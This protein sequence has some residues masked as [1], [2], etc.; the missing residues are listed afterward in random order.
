MCV[1]GSSSGGNCIY[2]ASDATAILIDAGLSARDTL[3]RL[4]QIGVAAAGLAAICLTHEH[5]DHT[6]GL[7][8]LHRRTGAQLFANSGTIEALA[9]R[10]GPGALP[11]NVFTTGSA[12]RIG[13]LELEPFSVPHDAYD[14]VGFVVA[15][16]GARVGIVTDMG[17]ATGLIRERLR[18]CHAIV[19]E[20]NHDAELLHDAERPW[21]LKQR[22]QGRQGHLSNADAAALITE[23]AGP[24]LRAV[25]LAHLSG[26]CNRP[27]LAREA[28]VEA[29]P[30]GRREHVV[31]RVAAADRVSELWVSG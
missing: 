2:V 17:M 7:V 23:I 10:W 26:E 27:D 15:G 21:S 19:V 13:D 3:R 9:R 12:F 29:L 24:D 6:D 4:E 31:V 28:A 30:P 1:L 16:A 20:A 25:Y 8:V 11:W 5:S 22:I 14:P 18:R